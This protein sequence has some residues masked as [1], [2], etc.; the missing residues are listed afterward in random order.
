[1]VTGNFAMLIGADP[2]AVHEWYLSVYLDAFEWVEMPNV[3]G[4]S[5]YGDGGLLGSKPYASSGAYINRMSNYCSEC[6]YNVKERTGDTACPFNSLYWHFFARNENKLRGNN[7][8]NMVYRNLD[9]MERKTRQG[10]IDQANA[11]LEDL[12][13]APASD[14]L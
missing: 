4:M 2:H 1:M 5:Q 8:L 7:R 3:I 9:K 13:E 10:L 11:F 12:G 6:A 14:Y